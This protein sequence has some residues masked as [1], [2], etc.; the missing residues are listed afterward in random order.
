MVAVKRNHTRALTAR[1]GGEGGITAQ[2]IPTRRSD[3]TGRDR[4]PKERSPREHTR[5]TPS[6]T[7]PVFPGRGPFVGHPFLPERAQPSAG[8][9]LAHG[10]S[11]L[12]LLSLSVPRRASLAAD[13]LEHVP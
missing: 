12:V 3:E 2:Q 13:V 7:P 1:R 11:S 10:L 9:A 4:P 5:R 6:A 8:L